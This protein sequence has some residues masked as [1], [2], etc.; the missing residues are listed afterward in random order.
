MDRT[1]P[2][3]LQPLQ[4]N[5]R[6]K[7][8]APTGQGVAGPTA[9]EQTAQGSAGKNE[10]QHAAPGGAHS[11]G[12]RMSIPLPPG[13]D[14]ERFRSMMPNGIDKESVQ[15]MLAIQRQRLASSPLAQQVIVLCYY[16]KSL[17]A[18]FLSR[19]AGYVWNHW[20][21]GFERQSSPIPV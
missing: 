3:G 1:A 10:Q 11:E 15:R 6:P 20:Q 9:L 12:P 2:I 14:M 13:F 4:R 17:C 8:E 21:C 16:C 7:A 19:T 18:I 5:R